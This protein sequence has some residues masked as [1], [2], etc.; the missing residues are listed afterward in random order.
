MTCTKDA[1]GNVTEVVSASS[2]EANSDVD[3]AVL[4]ANTSR[5]LLSVGPSTAFQTS[6][7]VNID[8][9]A[10]SGAQGIVPGAIGINSLGTDCWSN[11]SGIR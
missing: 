10:P 7:N 3:A 9:E 1:G 4:A 2:S 5:E 8:F 6:N 11:W